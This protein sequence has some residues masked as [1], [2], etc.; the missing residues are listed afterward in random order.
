MKTLALMR[1]IAEGTRAQPARAGLA[2]AC[3]S[4]GMAALVSLLAIVGGLRQKTR[5]MIG[6]LGVN[7]FGMTQPGDTASGSSSLPLTRRHV[8]YLAANLEGANVTGLRLEDGTAAGLPP[9]A[10]LAASDETLFKVRPWRIVQGRPFDAGDIRDRA[11][12]AIVS[13]TLARDMKLAPGDT[14]RLR[15]TTLRVIGLV[16]TGTGA[17]ETGAPQHALAPGS[18]L[19]LIPWS[20]PAWWASAPFA[21]PNRLDSIFI[22]GAEG[23]PLGDLIRRTENLMLQ[24][25][26]ACKGLS[27]VTPEGLIRRLLHYQRLVMLAG[28]AIVLLCLALGG[29]TLSSLLLSGIQARVP[30]IGLRRAL[31]ASSADIGILFMSEALLITLAASMAGSCGAWAFLALTRQWSPVPIDLGPA[32]IAI[33]LVTGVIL[34]FAFS[35][36]PARA[37]A[38]V[39]PSEALRND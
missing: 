24:P 37:A 25:D 39:S 2:F 1:D 38:R 34:G 26:Y 29:I 14:V 13:T 12:Y 5:G 7:V 28:G 27:W 3:L 20:L 30:E 16:D 6:E 22:K 19:I 21:T 15:T 31:G 23:I 10:V 32:V 18:R 33:P 35:Y 8:A 17:L 9:G 4:L 11:R 36:W